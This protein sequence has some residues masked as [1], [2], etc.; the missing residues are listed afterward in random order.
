MNQAVNECAP[1]QGQERAS[2]FLRELALMQRLVSFRGAFG[3]IERQRKR[4][5]A[6]QYALSTRNPVAYEEGLA[7]QSEEQIR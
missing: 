7:R 3:L 4:L 5:A 1:C 6:Q 2:L